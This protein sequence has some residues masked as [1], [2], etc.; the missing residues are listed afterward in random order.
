MA[1]LLTGW[2]NVNHDNNLMSSFD[3]QIQ[4]L[5]ICTAH[6]FFVRTDR[7]KAISGKEYTV[8]AA[9]TGALLRCTT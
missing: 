3:H 9:H 8:F 7:A 2:T 5:F 6:C 1:N 4:A